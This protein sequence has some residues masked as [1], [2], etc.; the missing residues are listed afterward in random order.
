[1]TQQ[2][3]GAAL[4]AQGLRTGGA[5]G[6]ELLAQAV[7]AF[8]SALEVITREQLPQDWA[9]TQHNLGAALKEQAIRTGGAQATELLAQAV[10]AYRRALEVYTPEVFPA[11]HARVQANLAKAEDLLEQTKAPQ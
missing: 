3:L 4:Q 2:N 5:Q 8:R 6:T 9:M 1:M 7:A 10:A 11:Y